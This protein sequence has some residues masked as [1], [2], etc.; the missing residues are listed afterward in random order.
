LPDGH[1][2]TLE[3]WAVMKDYRLALAH[4]LTK[5]VENSEEEAEIK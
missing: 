2:E 3:E 4:K 1:N 5:S